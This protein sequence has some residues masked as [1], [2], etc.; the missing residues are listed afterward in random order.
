MGDQIKELEGIEQR[1]KNLINHLNQIEMKISDVENRR[2]S[3]IV[4]N[5]SRLPNEFVRVI[6]EALDDQKEVIITPRMSDV[7][8]RVMD[9]G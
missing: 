2:K 8:I 9:E 1:V 7:E 6:F 5:I 4:F 3:V